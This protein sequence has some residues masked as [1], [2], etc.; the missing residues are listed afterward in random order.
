[1]ISFSVGFGWMQ[2]CEICTFVWKQIL[3]DVYMYL[4]VRS[5]INVN[6]LQNLQ[7]WKKFKQKAQIMISDL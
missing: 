5:K 6:K 7:R 4:P 2:I 1:M 3:N